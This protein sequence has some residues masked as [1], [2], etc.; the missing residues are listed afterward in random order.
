MVGI[1][2]SQAFEM[3]RVRGFDLSYESLTGFAAR[4]KLRGLKT[5]DPEF[6]KELTGGDSSV[7]V[8]NT[9]PDLP[10]E[11]DVELQ[12]CAFDDDSN[13]PCTVVI[14][15]VT[16]LGPASSNKHLSRAEAETMDF[17]VERVVEEGNVTNVE[18][19]GD[20]ERKVELGRGRRMRKANTLYMHT[21]WRHHDDDE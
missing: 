8:A 3:C 16:G 1:D 15:N 18:A 6:W 10:V 11:D 4:E 5:N 21:F 7:E 20:G 19:V 12:E 2:T 9:V 17:E 14:A 13:L